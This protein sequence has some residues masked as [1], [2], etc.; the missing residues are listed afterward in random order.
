[1]L[2]LDVEVEGDVGAVEAVALFVGAEEALLYL[3]GH[4]AVFLAVLQPIYPE[5]FI[6][7][8]LGYFRATSICAMSSLSLV[9]FSVASL[10]SAQLISFWR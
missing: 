7:Q 4:S 2:D 10:I 8:I 9:F 5:M 1:M 3:G 6:L